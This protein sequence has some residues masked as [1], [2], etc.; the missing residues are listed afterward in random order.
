MKPLVTVLL[1]PVVREGETADVVKTSEVSS[2]E[3]ALAVGLGTVE[4]SVLTVV[5]VMVLF[6]VDC[7]E[8]DD[9]TGPL[10]G[11]ADPENVAEELTRADEDDAT[12]TG[13]DTSKIELDAVA[14]KDEADDSRLV[15]GVSPVIGNVV[16]QIDTEMSSEIVVEKCS[17]VVQIVLD[18]LP[19]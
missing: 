4:T 14:F 8:L 11:A 1:A 9:S 16:V 10:D 3:L 17:V 2:E 15:T 18:E 6:R 5:C 19:V 12:T 13:V 7:K